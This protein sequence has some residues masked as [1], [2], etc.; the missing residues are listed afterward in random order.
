[1]WI[2]NFKHL[3]LMNFLLVVTVLIKHFFLL[4][5]ISSIYLATTNF[6]TI[7]DP[8]FLDVIHLYLYLYLYSDI[9]YKKPSNGKADVKSYYCYYHY[10]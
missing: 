2:E 3:Y 1:M 5:K 9:S 4:S 8:W 10:Y 6:S 7:Y